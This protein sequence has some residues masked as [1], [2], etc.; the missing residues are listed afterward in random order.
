MDSLNTIN[1]PSSLPLPDLAVHQNSFL[2]NIAKE[3]TAERNNSGQRFRDATIPGCLPC[4][5]NPPMAQLENE[6]S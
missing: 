5:N 3:I 2:Q 6:S 4:L 1:I